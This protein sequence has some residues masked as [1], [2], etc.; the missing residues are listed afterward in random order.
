MKGAHCAGAG[1]I[2]AG[3]E[4]LAQLAQRAQQRGCEAQPA[5]GGPHGQPRHVQAQHRL[6]CTILALLPHQL[7]LRR[8][9]KPLPPL[10]LDQ[11]QH[12]E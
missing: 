4:L 6:C 11:E 12:G 5:V 3:R 2:P 1:G 7:R 8:V 9:T 10:Y